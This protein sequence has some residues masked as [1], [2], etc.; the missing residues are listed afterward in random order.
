MNKGR[1]SAESSKA[2][3]RFLK[4]VFRKKFLTTGLYSSV[5]RTENPV[6]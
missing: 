3:G 2:R 1:L 6:L 4:E 5:P